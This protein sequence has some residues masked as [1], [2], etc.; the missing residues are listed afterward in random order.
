[1]VLNDQINQL[2]QTL[3]ETVQYGWEASDSTLIPIMILP[4]SLALIELSTCECKSECTDGR[5]KCYKNYLV[6]IDM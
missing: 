2:M 3:P 4:A 1:M 5:C 6:C